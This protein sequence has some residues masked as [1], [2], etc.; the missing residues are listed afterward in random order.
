MD[1]LDFLQSL[2]ARATRRVETTALLR[3]CIRKAVSQHGAVAF[4]ATSDMTRLGDARAGLADVLKHSAPHARPR[5]QPLRPS[6]DRIH[7]E[8]F[9]HGWSGA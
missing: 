8:A 5:T 9:G 6:R 3:L 7:E 1:L 4:D 2:C